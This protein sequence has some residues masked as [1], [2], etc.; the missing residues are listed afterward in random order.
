MVGKEKPEKEVIDED[1]LEENMF[2]PTSK[3]YVPEKKIRG[4]VKKIEGMIKN[5]EGEIKNTEGE[6]QNTKDKYAGILDLMTQED[7]KKIEDM[8]KKISALKEPLPAL[9]NSLPAL[10]DLISVYGDRSVDLD[11]AAGEIGDRAPGLGHDVPREEVIGVLK[12]HHKL[13]DNFPEFKDVQSSELP[14][15]SLNE[16]KLR[17]AIRNIIRETLSK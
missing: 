14:D 9:K 2:Q 1:P 6:I 3:N 17:K 4:M 15:F 8:R 5:T 13:M 16:T 12:T 10:E 7:R 11:I